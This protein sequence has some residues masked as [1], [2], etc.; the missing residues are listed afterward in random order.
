[1]GQAIVAPVL[2]EIGWT[3]RKAWTSREG[4]A[5]PADRRSA[6]EEHEGAVPSPIEPLNDGESETLGDRF[7]DFRPDVM[8]LCTRLIGRDDAE[9]ATHEV[10]LRAQARIDSYDSTRPFRR[11]LLAIGSNHCI[12]RLRRRGTERL[13]FLPGEADAHPSA[14]PQPTA[15]DGIVR[16]QNRLAVLAALDQLP[17]LYRAP[18]VLRY[19]AELDYDAIAVELELTRSQV[20]TL[21]FRGKR[22]LRAIL[23][24][25][26]DALQ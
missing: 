4:P 24:V 21:L 11:W 18:L 19:F 20:G 10:F 6:K 16:G 13:L 5:V 9:D 12:D 14:T 1:V 7:E 17:D 8:R 15:L 23:R 2:W 26:E 22:R 25:E 3:G